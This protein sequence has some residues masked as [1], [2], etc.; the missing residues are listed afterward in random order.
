[1]GASRTV[2][3]P[4]T[5]EWGQTASGLWVRFLIIPLL[6]GFKITGGDLEFE[7]VHMAHWK[8]QPTVKSLV[9]LQTCFGSLTGWTT[10]KRA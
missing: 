2:L 5:E 1:M 6:V 9:Y 4:L 8:E 10:W 3:D 7:M